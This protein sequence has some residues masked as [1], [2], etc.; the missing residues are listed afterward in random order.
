MQSFQML[1]GGEYPRAFCKYAA[2]IIKK[3]QQ[4]MPRV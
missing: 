3:R 1:I 4:T 2:K